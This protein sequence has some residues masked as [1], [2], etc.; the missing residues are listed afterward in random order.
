MAK[1][2]SPKAIL[3]K[4]SG[5]PEEDIGDVMEAVQENL[6]KLKTCSRHDFGEHVP[7]KNS[8]TCSR[9]G[10]WVDAEARYWYRKGLKHAVP[11]T[12]SGCAAFVGIPGTTFLCQHAAKVVKGDG[13]DQACEH[14]VS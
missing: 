14:V 7:M 13:T 10:G 8:Y 1:I 12:C 3:S 5:I 2:H 6:D 4:M 9:C 11:G